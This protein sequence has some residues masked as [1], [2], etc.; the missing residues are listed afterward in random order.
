[1][2]VREDDAA[3]KKKKKKNSANLARSSLE[4]LICSIKRCTLS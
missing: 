3:V 2:L 4:G 1:M